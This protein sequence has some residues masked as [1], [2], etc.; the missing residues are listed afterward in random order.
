MTTRIGNKWYHPILW[1]KEYIKDWACCERTLLLTRAVD[2]LWRNLFLCKDEYKVT[3]RLAELKFEAVAHQR[4]FTGK[5]YLLMS[6]EIV[7]CLLVV[8]LL[9]LLVAKFISHKTLVLVPKRKLDA[10]REQ[11][12]R[13]SRNSI[14]KTELDSLRA[15]LKIA[16]SDRPDGISPA[17]RDDYRRFLKEQTLTFA[18]SQQLMEFYKKNNIKVG[19]EPIQVDESRLDFSEYPEQAEL[20]KEITKYLIQTINDQISKSSATSIRER[21]IVTFPTLQTPFATMHNIQVDPEKTWATNEE[22]H[23]KGSLLGCATDKLIALGA[24]YGLIPHGR[25]CWILQA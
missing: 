15:Q 22:Y 25:R 10:V 23:I 5:D 12:Q 14:P 9:I 7:L 8:P 11:L 4:V 21:R 20:L 3:K 6:A 24:L 19:N 18:P 17:E 16:R 13:E 2:T 1:E